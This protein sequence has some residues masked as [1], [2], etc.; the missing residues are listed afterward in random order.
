MNKQNRTPFAERVKNAPSLEFLMNRILSQD[1]NKGGSKN[2]S[3]T[4]T[5]KSGI[6][7]GSNISQHSCAP[8]LL[9]Q[10]CEPHSQ[11]NK[12]I[13]LRERTIQ[14]VLNNVISKKMLFVLVKA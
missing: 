4:L 12:S 1:T 2:K 3:T 14:T 9:V 11:T 6:K 7:F 10:K 5:Y 13:Y 8:S